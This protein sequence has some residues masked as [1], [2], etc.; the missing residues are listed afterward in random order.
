MPTTQP[1]IAAT[2]HAPQ[3][4]RKKEKWTP[5]ESIIDYRCFTLSLLSVA[6]KLG[7]GTEEFPLVFRQVFGKDNVDTALNSVLLIR[8]HDLI[9]RLDVNKINLIS[10]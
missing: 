2:A 3:E 4:R 7:E 1:L 10:S 6:S 5:V 9:I 8:M